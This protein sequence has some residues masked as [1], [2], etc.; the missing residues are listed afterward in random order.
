MEAETN[1]CYA[2]IT[3]GVCVSA[4][5]PTRVEPLGGGGDCFNT[6]PQ[7]RIINGRYLYTI[8]ILEPFHPLRPSI[9]SIGIQII[10][11][12]AEGDLPTYPGED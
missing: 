10:A 12:N 2:V 6:N 11:N 8:D 7:P 1:S 5:F 9:A 4:L 3:H